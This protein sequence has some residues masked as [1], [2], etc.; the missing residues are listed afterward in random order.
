MQIM[1]A[2]ILENSTFIS[3]KCKKC[4]EQFILKSYIM[5]FDKIIKIMQC[6][7]LNFINQYMQILYYVR[8]NN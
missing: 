3:K 5:Q 7:Q 8:Y 1:K 4:V 2:I 6:I